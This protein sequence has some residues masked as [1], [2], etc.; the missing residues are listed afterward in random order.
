[1]MTLSLTVH[2]ALEDEW[3]TQ[4]LD[5][6]G[7]V[8]VVQADIDHRR[9]AGIRCAVVGVGNLRY[10]PVWVAVCDG[11]VLQDFEELG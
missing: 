4:N 2:L 10:D 5:T 6:I 9:E 11:L 8:G 7:L 3:S 1:M